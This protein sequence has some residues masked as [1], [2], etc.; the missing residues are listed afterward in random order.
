MTSDLDRAYQALQD[1][2][3]AEGLAFYRALADVELF[4]LLEGEAAGEVMT[5][6]VFDLAEGAVVLAFDSE[7]RLAGFAD[8]PQPYA[9][10]PGRVIA[11]QMAGKGLALGLNL[12]SA[13]ASEV[14]LPREALE[15]LVQMLDQAPPE[16]V[17]ARIAGFEAPVVPAA[18]LRALTGSLP[19]KAY[20][21]GVR[22]GD[23]R[24]GQMLAVVGGAP[25]DKVARAVTEALAFSGIAA[26]TLDVTFL[27]ADDPALA[28]M[29]GLALV[30]EGQMPPGADVAAPVGPGMDRA[31]PP[32]LR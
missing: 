26:G 18:V 11:G 12:G 31:R 14:I 21:V 32:I 28:R 15:W 4:L 19:G 8:G 3:E 23:G 30:F 10:L 9:A 17:E 22:Y 6:R 29:A 25:N 2:G 1:G 20:L 16:A 5:P 13:A 24:R 27:A 7:E